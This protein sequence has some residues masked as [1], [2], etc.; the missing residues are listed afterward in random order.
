MSDRRSTI[1]R[2]RDDVGSLTGEAA[3]M[4]RLRWELMR[5]ELAE[6]AKRLKWLLIVWA[7]AAVMLLSAVPVLVVAVAYAIDGAWGLS[8]LGWLLVLGTGMIVVAVLGSLLAWTIFRRNLTA[9]RETLVEFEEDRLW[10]E[11]WRGEKSGG[12]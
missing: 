3:E 2:L 1:G 7:V 4:L 6:D 10:L 11:E 8:H 5:L 12:E 9:L